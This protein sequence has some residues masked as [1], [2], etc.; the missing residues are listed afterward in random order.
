[1]FNLLLYTYRS[2]FDFFAI[3]CIHVL[4]CEQNVIWQTKLC[5]LREPCFQY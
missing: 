5:F 4:W 1:M 2:D 3:I